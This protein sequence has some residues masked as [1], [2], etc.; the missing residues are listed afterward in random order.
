MTQGLTKK[1]VSKKDRALADLLEAARRVIS[2]PQFSACE[3]GKR[4]CTTKQLRDAIRKA[5]AA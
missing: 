1:K 2:H 4:G 5:E 3:C